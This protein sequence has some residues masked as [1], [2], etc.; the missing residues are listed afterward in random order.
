MWRGCPRPRLVQSLRSLGR[1]GLLQRSGYADARRSFNITEA[2]SNAACTASVSQR[3]AGTRLSGY[4]GCSFAPDPTDRMARAVEGQRSRCIRLV[5]I[6]EQLI[7]RRRT[8][9]MRADLGCG[10]SDQRSIR[11]HVV[12]PRSSHALAGSAT[13]NRGGTE[14][15][16]TKWPT[17]ESCNR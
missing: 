17:S 2:H 12:S 6:S 13:A 15:T 3:F 14:V 10:R 1:V 4:P 7:R 9:R 8:A 5:P 16:A 11:P